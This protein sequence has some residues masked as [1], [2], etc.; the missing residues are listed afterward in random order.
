MKAIRL[1]SRSLLMKMQQKNRLPRWGQAVLGKSEGADLLHGGSRGGD[2]DGGEH[3]AE[4]ALVQA[5][6]LGGDGGLHHD[7]G[8][9]LQL[10]GGGPLAGQ[11][12]ELDIVHAA[13]H[14][15]AAGGKHRLLIPAQHCNLTLEGN[16]LAVKIL[17]GVQGG[18]QL[19][20]LAD[21][22]LNQLGEEG[23]VENVLVENCVLWCDWG[24][25]LET[26]CGHK[27]TEIKNVTFRNNCLIHL[28]A[29]AMNITVWYGSNH[30]VVDNVLYE[31]IFIDLDEKF[32]FYTY[33]HYNDF[34]EYLNYEGGW[35]EMFGNITGGGT[36]SSKYDYN[37]TPYV[38]VVRS[39]FVNNQSL[40]VMFD[41]IVPSF[42]KEEMFL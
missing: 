9:G 6:L 7:P 23:N 21:G 16:G 30:S 31:N 18:G 11:T 35:G 19:G 4:I 42:K 2:G 25:S 29:V 28:N 34:Q 33:N 14:D 13:G 24:K 5:V 22:A 39:E 38:E 10:L 37:P 36:L 8:T 20:E 12:A 17:G 15:K 40:N 26:W 3:G 1:T 32:L 27:P 41:F